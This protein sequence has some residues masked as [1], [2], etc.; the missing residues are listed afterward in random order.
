MSKRPIEVEC[1]MTTCKAEPDEFCKN[2]DGSRRRLGFHSVR[3]EFA[4]RVDDPNANQ[5]KAGLM[6]YAGTKLLNG[7]RSSRKR[8]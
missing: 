4:K 6:R 3:V 5:I 8:A 1:P 2:P 7:L